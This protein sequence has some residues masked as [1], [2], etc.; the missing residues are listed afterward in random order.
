[1][2]RER[3]PLSLQMHD[4]AM[5]GRSFIHEHRGNSNIWYEDNSLV[6]SGDLLKTGT[7]IPMPEDKFSVHPPDDVVSL[8]NYTRDGVPVMLYDVAEIKF[9]PKSSED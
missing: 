1:M 7:K 2:V 5:F 9:L 6:E 4:L 8:T 3:S